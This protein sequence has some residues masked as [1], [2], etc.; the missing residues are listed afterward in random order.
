MMMCSLPLA[1]ETR[2]GGGAAS[3]AAVVCHSTQPTETEYAEAH[4]PFSIND[5]VDPIAMQNSVERIVR[6]LHSRIRHD[7]DENPVRRLNK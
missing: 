7:D 4:S 2:A 3:A 1:A 6:I 5:T